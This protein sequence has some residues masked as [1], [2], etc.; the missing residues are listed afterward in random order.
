M[1]FKF[2]HLY[3][4]EDRFKESKSLSLKY[5]ERIPVICEA[6]NPKCQKLKLDKDK[7]LCSKHMTVSQFYYM[8]R[9]RLSANDDPKLIFFVNRKII[10]GN[11]TLGYIYDRYR[12]EDGFLYITYGENIKWALK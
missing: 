11:M 9:T 1:S 2:K 6:E 7:F 3:S 10:N 8:I 4:S 5:P 12:D